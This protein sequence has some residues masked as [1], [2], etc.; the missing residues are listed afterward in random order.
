MTLEEKRR[1][2]KQLIQLKI[3]TES[4]R[5]IHENKLPDHKTEQKRVL[6][7]IRPA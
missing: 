4:L 2:I 1:L 7:L 5:A 3:K 6:K